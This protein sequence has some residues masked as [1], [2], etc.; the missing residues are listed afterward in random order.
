MPAVDGEGYLDA[1][2]KTSSDT[3]VIVF[4]YNDQVCLVVYTYKVKV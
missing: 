2:E 4:I 3:T 1:I